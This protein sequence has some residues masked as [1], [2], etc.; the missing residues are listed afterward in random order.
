LSITGTPE[1]GEAKADLRI[2]FRV[3]VPTPFR[4][5]ASPR[6]ALSPEDGFQVE[7]AN[8]DTSIT[9]FAIDQTTTPRQVDV[10]GILAPGTYSIRYEIEVTV[11]DTENG[12]DFDFNFSLRPP[13]H[14]A[15]VADFDDGSGAGRPDGGI[16]IDDLV[17][18][19][20]LLDAGSICAD[21]DNGSATGTRD[22]GVTID[23]LL[24]LLTRYAAGC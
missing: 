1:F 15:C 17:Y 9:L 11:S 23:D 10:S 7:L 19:L 8:S 5:T 24:Y 4:L 13:C 2:S 20:S 12:A 3:D 21:V 14:G 16:T 22:G 6:P 18:F